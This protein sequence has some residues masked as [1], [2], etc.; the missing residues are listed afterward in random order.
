MA[1]EMVHRYSFNPTTRRWPLRLFVWLLDICALNA[2]VIW[3]HQQKKNG[4]NI[5]ANYQ[6]KFLKDLTSSLME[7]QKIVRASSKSAQNYVFVQYQ[8]MA[9]K[10][11]EM[12]QKLA[13][14][15]SNPMTYCLRCQD[16]KRESHFAICQGKCKLPACKDCLIETYICKTCNNGQTIIQKKISVELL[17][18]ASKTEFFLLR[19]D[20][21][22][23]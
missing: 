4:H 2:F 5:P 21:N 1:D 14:K 15:Q 22:K 19:Y 17:F 16:T 20:Q 3:K 18:T 12:Q 23:F 13:G 7:G 8:E 10:M 11:K 9:S 6:P